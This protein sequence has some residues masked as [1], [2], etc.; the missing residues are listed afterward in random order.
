MNTVTWTDDKIDL[1]AENVEVLDGK[2]VALDK[3][4]DVGFTRLEGRLDLESARTDV[5]FG[6]VNQQLGELRTGQ[7]ELTDRFDAMQRTLVQIGFGLAVGLLA[8]PG[9]Q[10]PPRLAVARRRRPPG[11]LEQRGDVV[12]ADL[13]AAVEPARAPA[14]RA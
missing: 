1:L 6:A 13:M 12:V 7:S 10:E 2:V 9:H 5:R 4:V 8:A 11:R 3:K 14:L